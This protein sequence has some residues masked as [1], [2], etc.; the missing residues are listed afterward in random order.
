MCRTIDL[1]WKLK[2][3]PI[4]PSPI[5]LKVSAILFSYPMRM[6]SLGIFEYGLSW[7]SAS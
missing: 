5:R 4:R 6:F 1:S 3:K 2:I 7:R